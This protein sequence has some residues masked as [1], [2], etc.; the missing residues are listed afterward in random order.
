[1]KI[2]QVCK[3]VLLSTAAASGLIISHSA[4][5]Q[6][7]AEHAQVADIVVTAE[8]RTSTVQRTPI[9]IT[10]ITGEVL[11]KRQLN[12]ITD[13]QGSVPGFRIGILTGGA[14]VSIR[15]I[16]ITNV[17]PTVEGAAAVN[18][19]DA[20]V[21]RI[22]AQSL[23]FYDVSSL[24]VLRGPQGTLYGR[25][26]TAG[27]LNI[28]TTLPDESFAGY[29]RLTVGNYNTINAEG[30]VGGPV[31]GDALL[32]R[33]A[34]RVERHSGYTRNLA[35]GRRVD[36]RNTW[37]ARATIVAT[38][39]PDVKVTI[40]GDIGEQ[41]DASS[42]GHYL[43]GGGLTGLPGASG[44]PPLA[45][46]EGGINPG[47]RHIAQD[48]EPSMRLWVR[49]LTGK[50]EWDASD[51]ITLRSI[52]GYRYTK[53]EQIF[54]TDFNAPTSL[55]FA[56]RD[57]AEQYSQELQALYTSDR[58]NVTIGGYYF[59]EKE[60]VPNADTGIKSTLLENI[61]CPVLGFACP[62]NS[63]NAYFSHGLSYRGRQRTTSWAGF[64]QADLHVTDKLTLTAGIRYTKERKALAQDLTAD[65][66]NTRPLSEPYTNF[67]Q[68]LPQNFAPYRV[69]K[70]NATTPKFGVQ[71]QVAPQTLLYASYSKGFK[72]GGF[73]LS[74]IAPA[75]NPEK[76]TDYEAGLKTRLFDNRV[77]FNLT[78]FLYRY[79]DL[80]VQQ[81][82]GLGTATVNAARATNYG[83]ELETQAALSDRLR[84]DLNAAYI[85]A[86]YDDY[87]GIDPD[88]PQLGSVDYSGNRLS[89]APR[90][91]G[92]LGAQ[93]TAPISDGELTLR[94]EVQYMS[95]Y[96][97]TPVNV[98]LESQPS[99][100]KGNLYLTYVAKAG[101]TAQLFV[102][103]ITNKITRESFST[104]GALL[105]NPL[106]G[107]VSP[108]R[109]I[110]ADLRYAF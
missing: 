8:R 52:S 91:S 30:A 46:Q 24:E 33:V 109:L 96:Y 107:S 69:A 61:V 66:S 19:N 9:A 99:F 90:L 5:A 2:R 95:R 38:P 62:A 73:E 50:I 97:L 71:Y 22:I 56:L 10:A 14:V 64:G 104:S 106:G 101:W 6:T 55:F 68:Y 12:A 88:R 82:R 85:H 15:G 44:M 16:G 79:D 78:G 75:Y 81:Q 37:A 11:A 72:G 28:H 39:A 48:I 18:I 100:A 89:N 3:A 94:G 74:S 42:V 36:D 58:L 87:I 41:D 102:R 93:Y 4:W 45:I 77:T 49:S 26:A 40:I 17:L 53:T 34:G 98:G 92:Q 59:H 43:G 67:G 65:L 20:Y 108:P 31:A 84:M 13:L 63:G 51:A 47:L 60:A 105:G 7:D 70:F 29:G 110:G 54:S 80:Q 86:T 23:S 32:V 76:L 27:A 57:R 35:T 1:M 103:N 25:N 83:L 21:A